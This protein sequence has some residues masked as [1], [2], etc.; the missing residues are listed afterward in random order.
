MFIA[1]FSYRFMCFGI[2]SMK[3]D[4]RCVSVFLEVLV[5]VCENRSLCK[6][7]HV[8]LEVVQIHVSVGV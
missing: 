3:C 7:V 6:C 1:G 4:I 5:V 2:K 8:G